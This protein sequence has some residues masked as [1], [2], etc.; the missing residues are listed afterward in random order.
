MVITA[1]EILNLDIESLRLDALVS[2]R[3]EIYEN[4]LLFST[5][6]E[7]IHQWGKIEKKLKMPHAAEV[8][9]KNALLLNKEHIE[10]MRELGFLYAENGKLDDALNLF[11]AIV[12][13]APDDWAA[14]NDGGCILRTIKD[15]N[16]AI[17]WMQM[18]AKANPSNTT[19]FANIALLYYEL[20]EY[21]KAQ[22][23]LNASF[24]LDQN[25][26]EALHTQAMLFSATGDH[27]KALEY[28]K[29]A[30]LSNPE[31]PQ[32]KLGLALSYLTLGDL[33]Q[34]FIG[35]EHRWNGSDKSDTKTMITFG[36]AQWYGQSVYKESVI[37]VLPEQG[38]GDMIQFAQLIPLLLRK[39]YKVYWFVPIELYALIKHSFTDGQ[40]IV[41]H[42][43][44]AIDAKKID[45]EIPLMSLG[46]ALNITQKTIP[47]EL[48][49]L[50]AQNTLVEMW[51]EKLKMLQGLKV[52]ICWTGKATLSKQKLRSIDP[53]LFKIID[54]PDISFV[55][56]QKYDQNMTFLK[57][58]IEHFY[59]FMDECNDFMQS[60]A[61]MTNLDLIITVDTSIAHLSAALAKPTWLLNRFGSEWR[62][63]DKREDSPWYP[64]MRIF[65]QKSLG[66]WDE[67]LEM[68]REVLVKILKER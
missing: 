65:N 13:I 12:T 47:G 16:K 54:L 10:S 55:S 45:Y 53:Q 37:A 15:V 50:K 8:C 32:A 64:T 52:G 14:W 48:W 24:A 4:Q 34:G 63:M 36:K 67:T 21:E 7:V 27:N 5:D 19:L 46:L 23:Y 20:F 29:K 61:L 6:Y 42:D 9:F 33:K 17:E 11:T 1:S 66:A 58:D 49:Y 35:Y 22:K 18:A 43:L 30:L 39:F 68:V 31:Y 3:N 62:W 44:S 28:D 38:F 56:L 59:D 41:H 60:A 26:A 57:P 40:I 51:K 2:I 25:Y